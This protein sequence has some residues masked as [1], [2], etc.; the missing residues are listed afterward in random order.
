MYEILILVILG[1]FLL[2]SLTLGI[3]DL[4]LINKQRKQLNDY[5]EELDETFDEFEKRLKEEFEI[6]DNALEGTSSALMRVSLKQLIYDYSI[7][8]GYQEELIKDENFEEAALVKSD[9]ARIKS[10]IRIAITHL[11]PE[12]AAE[13]A[14]FLEN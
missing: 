11:T 14:D 6:I 12:E 4:T 5:M 8:K 13:Y 3:I 1:V 10:S 9:M 2:A 7:L